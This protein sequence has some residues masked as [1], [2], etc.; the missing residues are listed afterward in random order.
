[1]L[2][3]ADVTLSGGENDVWIFQM[4]GDLTVSSAVKVIL[5]GGAQAK[6]VFWQLAGN[7]TLGTTSHFEGIILSQTAITLNTGSSMNGRALAQSNVALDQA[8]V[9]EP[10]L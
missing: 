5:S 1:V 2:I 9:V 8:T 6:N 7:A 3:P 4:S 10:T